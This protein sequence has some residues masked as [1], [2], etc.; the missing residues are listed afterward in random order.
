MKP[1]DFG[2]KTKYI[3]A[4]GKNL[5]IAPTGDWKTW[6]VAIKQE[7]C[8]QCGICVM[9]CPVQAMIEKDGRIHITPDYCKGCGVCINE[10]PKQAIF[11]VKGGQAH[12]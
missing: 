6:P 12:G 10:C 7:K 1:E 8:V 3:C 5:A 2:I 4:I 11:F 9:S